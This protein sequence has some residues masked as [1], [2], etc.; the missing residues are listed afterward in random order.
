MKIKISDK[1][2]FSFF[3][4]NIAT[5]YCKEFDNLLWFKFAELFGKEC[6]EAKKG[7][8]CPA[9]FIYSINYSPYYFI[10]EKQ[11]T[12]VQLNIKRWQEVTKSSGASDQLNRILSMLTG[13]H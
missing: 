3:D 11:F 8:I 7:Y 2:V 6:L 1:R 12:D 9:P 5:K 10:T 13:S 4:K